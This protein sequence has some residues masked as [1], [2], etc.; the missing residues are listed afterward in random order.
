MTCCRAEKRSADRNAALLDKNIVMSLANMSMNRQVM[1]LVTS[2]FVP[3]HGCKIAAAAI[4]C[5]AVDNR[6]IPQL[7]VVQKGL[8]SDLSGWTAPAHLSS[9]SA[10]ACKNSSTA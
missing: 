5:L 6:P 1:A 7:P 4:D 10:V 8:C 9:Q 2:R 3:D